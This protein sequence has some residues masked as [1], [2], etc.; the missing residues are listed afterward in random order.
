MS[1]SSGESQK[2]K[3]PDKSASKAAASP[4]PEKSKAKTKKTSS[5]K[6]TVS[7]TASKKSPPK[8]M[9]MA[10]MQSSLKSLETRMKRADTLT[11]KSVK[12]LEGVVE[13]LDARTQKD[14]ETQKSALS[15]RVG[16][17][18]NDLEEGLATTRAEIKAALASALANPNP[19]DVEAAVARAMS[20]LN[21][22]ETS[23]AQAIAKINRH[24]A[25]LAKAVEDRIVT[26]QIAATEALHRVQTQLSDQ[27]ESVESESAKAIGTIGGKV[28]TLS[29]ALEARQSR[30][31]ASLA[32]K[33]SDL[34]AQTQAEFDKKT[35]SMEERIKTLEAAEREAALQ[36]PD[37]M[38]AEI[39]A[40]VSALSGQIETLQTRLDEIDASF[41]A[42]QAQTDIMGQD[43]VKTQA[44]LQD[45]QSH[46][47]NA[48]QNSGGAQA[49][50]PP[51]PYPSE[52]ATQTP[53]PHAAPSPSRVSNVVNM[54]PASQPSANP[55]SQSISGEQSALAAHEPVEFDPSSYHQANPYAQPNMPQMMQQSAAT[56]FAQPEFAPELTPEA[57]EY[58]VNEPSSY[59]AEAY[60]E[61]GYSQEAYTQDSYSGENYRDVE[62]MPAGDPLLPYADPAYAENGSQ[63][64]HEP[65][66]TVR[67]GETGKS[68]KSRRKER[69]SKN[70]ESASG[71][72]SLLTARNLRVAALATGL[73]L[74]T[75]FIVKSFL[76][77]NSENP[78]A[79]QPKAPSSSAEQSLNEAPTPPDLMTEESLSPEMTVPGT[80][81]LETSPQETSAPNIQGAPQAEPTAPIGTYEDTAM[82]AIPEGGISTLESAAQNGDA[83]AQ[84]QLG[85]SYLEQN[86]VTDGV[87][88]IRSASQT[89]PAAQ[90]RLAKL[91]ENGIGVEKDTSLARD[92]TE[93]AARA[94]NRIAMHDLAIFYAYGNGDVSVD[95][96]TAAGWF[97]KAAERGVVDSQFNLAIL[98]ENGQGVEQSLPDAYFW[99]SVAGKQGD[100]TA[101]ARISALEGQ[102]SQSDVEA[103]KIRV[104][105]FS[106]VQINAA[107][108]GI[109]KDLPW[110]KTGPTAAAQSKAEITEAQT[111][112]TDMGFDIGPADG[113]MGERTRSAILGFQR[114]NNL[115]ETGQVNSAL[116]ERLENAS[117]A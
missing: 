55:Y 48:P 81:A 47:Q 63:P 94:G 82:P 2:N 108:N 54:V 19:S 112:L 13:S 75:L 38:S 36:R 78:V 49:Q 24:L 72:S 69:K 45:A 60:S 105:S 50:T 88:L 70:T 16:R 42:L 3:A 33:V 68:R 61:E 34:A 29:E 99:Y 9:T 73:T 6:K 20:R 100:Q 87:D 32:E 65:L 18:S 25:N 23:Q 101:A 52:Q 89:L 53:R 12:T 83:V 44:Q 59:M 106:P 10:E 58:P 41:T 116:I 109:F 17:L 67:I 95:M 37:G 90:Y 77:D 110:S 93:R 43:L 11:R 98:F 8:K 27:I 114:A 74:V 26:D 21:D 85:L 96:E 22:T 117:R 15:R 79:L 80:P 1:Q 30:M 46:N 40:N 7:K 31:D 76:T 4:S 39:S 5:R 91:Y 113:I 86:R 28:A 66:E 84:L 51:P 57:E 104:A 97:A 92:L 107:A 103:A 71:G 56:A 62:S 111:L 115:S 64:G 35:N 102:M 14:N